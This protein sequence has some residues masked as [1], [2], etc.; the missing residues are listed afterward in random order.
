MITKILDYLGD[1]TDVRT[2]AAY[3]VGA[4]TT[5]FGKG[6]LSASVIGVVDAAAGLIV[7]IDTWFAG[8]R[9]KQAEKATQDRTTALAVAARA[10]QAAVPAVAAHTAPPAATGGA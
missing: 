9:K 1:E 7:A 2:A 4:I 8:A 10:A 6:H 3:A 5:V